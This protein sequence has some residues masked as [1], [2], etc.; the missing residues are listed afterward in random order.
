MEIIILGLLMIQRCTIYEMKK[1]IETTFSSISSNSTGSIQS[2]V[3]KL[4]SRGMI[5]Y[6]EHVENGVNKKVYEITEAGKAYFVDRLSRP[7]LYKEKN[8]E[9]GKLFF[10][11]F[12]PADSRAGLVDAYIAEL[13]KEKSKLEEI[14]ARTG[15]RDAAVENYMR[16]L[17]AIGE[18][19]KFAQMLGCE[20]L[21]Q[22]IRDVAFF[23]YATLDLALAKIDFEMQ[24]FEQLKKQMEG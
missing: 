17:K 11:G 7:M 15:D 19:E 10:M 24:W 16:H 18:E 9:L 3:K 2:A 8:M 5:A 23:Q 14:H 13:R 20:C 21:P 6:D 1:R 22:G 12:A 4:L